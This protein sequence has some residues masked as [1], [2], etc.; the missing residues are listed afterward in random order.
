MSRFL[1][2]RYAKLEAYV[3]GEQPTECH[4]IKLNTNESPFPPSPEVLALANADQAALLRLYPDPD[5]G[6]LRKKLAAYYQVSEQ[7]VI[8]ANGSDDILNLAFMAF[9]STEYPVCFPDITYGFYS[10]FSDLHG[11]SSRKIPLETDFSINPDQYRDG[12]IVLAN[13]NA[14]TGLSLSVAQI[15]SIV[16]A[17]PNHVVLID[18]AYV[19][20]GGQ[21]CVELT[22]QYD[23]LLVVMTFS[24]SRN[25]AG[26]RIG[27]AVGTIALIDD[28][29]R[30][31][32]SINPY[33]VNRFSLA[34]GTAAI[35]S[36]TYYDTC[37]QE[38]IRIRETTA[39]KLKALGFTVIPSHG[40][41]LF[42]K[43]ETLA[44]DKFY[45]ALRAHGILARHWDHKRICDYIRVSIGTE[46]EMETFVETT[47]AITKEFL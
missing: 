25:L 21:S 30:I 27:F 29:N 20:F 6:T 26:A 12:F 33:S 10:V 38:I 7:N 36:Q 13:P 11:I 17:N 14:P 9:G 39:A 22:R 1:N 34:I 41:F 40:N 45:H 46:A 32:N 42:I 8:V 35:D 5:C 28:L 15:E 31:K 4:Y 19:D 3:P 18:E 37:C 47:Q 23:N 2:P 44:G 43:K 16:K 24:K